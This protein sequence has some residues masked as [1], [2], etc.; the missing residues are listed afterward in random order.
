MGPD[1]IERVKERLV[2]R[3]V[4]EL[5]VV[6]VVPLERPVRWRRQDQ[7]QAAFR[8]AVQPP[9]IGVNELV[10]GMKPLHRRF[11]PPNRC[12]ITGQLWEDVVQASVSGN[13]GDEVRAIVESIRKSL[14]SQNGNAKSGSG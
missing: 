5:L 13:L 10:L 1:L 14:H 7:M 8:K 3:D 9:R 4:P 2:V 12:R 6:F 11:D